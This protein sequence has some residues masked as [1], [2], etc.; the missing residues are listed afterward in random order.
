MVARHDDDAAADVRDGRP[1]PCLR[2]ATASRVPA[3]RAPVRRVGA[4][5]SAERMS[6][7]PLR[8]AR[9]AST[10]TWRTR[11]TSSS[12]RTGP[13]SARSRRRADARA[14]GCRRR[15]R[16]RTSGEVPG[17]SARFA[18][19]DTVSVNPNGTDE[20]TLSAISVT[21]QT[22]LH[23]R[24][25]R[26][27]G[28]VA[29]GN[30][31]RSRCG[32]CRARCRI[33]STRCRR[34]DRDARLRR[35]VVGRRDHDPTRR[36]RLGGGGERS[37]RAPPGGW[38]TASGVGSRHGAAAS[39]PAGQRRGLAGQQRTVLPVLPRRRCLRRTG[40]ARR[41]APQRLAHRAGTRRHS[42]IRPRRS[43]RSTISPI[44]G[45]RAVRGSS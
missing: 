15:L 41:A 16:R 27:S 13:R 3:G 39:L 25:V 20:E 36:P 4:P 2:A 37:R 29:S 11:S 17:M 40:P 5:P 19:S 30:R 26:H 33:A 9:R 14:G 22:D 28:V 24:R 45:S 42:P 6:S 12:T 1:R 35:R 18:V 38:S 34:R 44:R 21:G 23:A 7:T 43:C 32:G 8:P 10:A 31:W